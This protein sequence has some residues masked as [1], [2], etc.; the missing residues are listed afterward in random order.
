MKAPVS[1]VSTSGTLMVWLTLTWK[2]SVTPAV[3]PGG[4]AMIGQLDTV[5]GVVSGS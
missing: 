2:G 5:I 4:G 3:A 1:L